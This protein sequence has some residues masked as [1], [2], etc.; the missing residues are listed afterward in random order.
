MVTFGEVIDSLTDRNLLPGKSVVELLNVNGTDISVAT[1]CAPEHMAYAINHLDGNIA[2]L[3]CI[4]ILGFYSEDSRLLKLTWIDQYSL[5]WQRPFFQ[6]YVW[7]ENGGY[8][9]KFTT[10]PVIW[11]SKNPQNCKVQ[12]IE[13]ASDFEM[14]KPYQVEL[15]KLRTASFITMSPQETFEYWKNNRGEIFLSVRKDQVKI[16][17]LPQ[18]KIYWIH[19]DNFN[20]L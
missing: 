19:M 14:L 9:S 5:S 7:Q 12:F 16:D 4:E 3:D 11:N 6:D 2:P 15:Q 20:K 1:I 13:K 10:L 17:V 18:K 8:Q